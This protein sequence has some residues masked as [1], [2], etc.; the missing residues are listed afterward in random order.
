MGK[1]FKAAVRCRSHRTLER[2]S[3]RIVVQEQN[4]LR[5]FAP[6]FAR[7]PDADVSIRLQST[8]RLW[9]DLAQDKSKYYV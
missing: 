1:N 5:H 4:A 8:Y 7:S 9:Y 6:P 2:V 3:W